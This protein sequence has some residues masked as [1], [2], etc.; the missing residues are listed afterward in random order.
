MT[1]F[2]IHLQKP[3][4]N[5]DIDKFTD[6]VLIISKTS[7]YFKDLEKSI[8]CEGGFSYFD[9]CD[10]IFGDTYKNSTR[11]KRYIERIYSQEPIG[12]REKWS[13]NEINEFN[14]IV[15]SYFTE[16]C[17]ELTIFKK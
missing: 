6:H 2:I 15:N 11:S 9:K 4:K 17:T 5:K 10:I 14:T 7:K 13:I 12:F 3:I 1:D 8:S 16:N